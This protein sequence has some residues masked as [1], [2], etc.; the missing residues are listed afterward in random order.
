VIHTAPDSDITTAV[1][2]TDYNQCASPSRQ[3][4]LSMALP[5][6]DKRRGAAVP[7]SAEVKSLFHSNHSLFTERNSLLN[8]SQIVCQS[9]A[10]LLN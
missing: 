6:V 8:S 5:R 1:L 7:C 2:E 9:I 4:P 3:K 10:N